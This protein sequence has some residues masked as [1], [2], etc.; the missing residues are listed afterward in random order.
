MLPIVLLFSYKAQAHDI[1]FFLVQGTHCSQFDFFEMEKRSE[2]INYSV[3]ASLAKRHVDIVTSR[4]QVM[5]DEL[6]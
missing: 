5:V 1:K 6:G 3:V 2:S 4:V